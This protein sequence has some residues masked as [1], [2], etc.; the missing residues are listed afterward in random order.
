MPTRMRGNFSSRKAR[1]RGV[2]QRDFVPDRLT[3]DGIRAV[4]GLTYVLARLALRKHCAIVNAFAD[5]VRENLRG[6]TTAIA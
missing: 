6:F 5:I 3:G 4:N 2:L 1:P